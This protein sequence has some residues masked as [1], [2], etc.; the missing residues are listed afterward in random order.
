MLVN[1]LYVQASMFIYMESI[2][3]VEFF[4]G[5]VSI[6]VLPNYFIAWIATSAGCSLAKRRKQP[7]TVWQ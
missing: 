7:G 6:S 1:S 5:F 3:S 2:Y 4:K